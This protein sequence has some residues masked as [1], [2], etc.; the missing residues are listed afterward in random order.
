MELDFRKQLVPVQ[1]FVI[2]MYLHTVH[3]GCIHGVE[4]NHKQIL[5]F[6]KHRTK[7]EK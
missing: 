3:S 7:V 5:F 2:T 6:K 4:Q 1:F